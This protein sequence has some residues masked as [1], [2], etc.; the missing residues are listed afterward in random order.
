MRFYNQ[1]RP[2]YCR[3]DLHARTMYLC[4][5]DQAGNNVLHKN[6]KARPASLLHAVRP[7]REGLV[8]GCECMF[9]QL[10][11]CL[12][13]RA[14][15]RFDR[16]AADGNHKRK[17]FLASHTPE[18]TKPIPTEPGDKKVK[19]SRTNRGTRT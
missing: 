6:I 16:R 4:I 13:R 9:A 7:F 14:G 18:S 5:L 2:F 3:L 10:D 17:S 12:V 8:I 15:Q 19:P 11:R 1:Q